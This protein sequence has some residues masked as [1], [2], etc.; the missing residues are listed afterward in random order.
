MLFPTNYLQ[1]HHLPAAEALVI[2]SVTVHTVAVSFSSLQYTVKL[3]PI[4]PLTEELVT[5]TQ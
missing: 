3:G 5:L 4:L 1:F 2:D